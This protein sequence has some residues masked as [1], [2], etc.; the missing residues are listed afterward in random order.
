MKMI[1]SALL[2]MVCTAQNLNGLLNCAT[3]KRDRM[4]KA[5]LS[6]DQYGKE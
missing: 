5:C 1:Y 2:Q 4:I 3:I 6:Y